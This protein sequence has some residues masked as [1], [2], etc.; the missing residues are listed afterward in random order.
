MKCNKSLYTVS[1][2]EKVTK[3]KIRK[4]RSSCFKQTKRWKKMFFEIGLT[5]PRWYIDPTPHCPFKI[6]PSHIP[7]EKEMGVLGS[8]LSRKDRYR[9]SLLR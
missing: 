7:P 9:G 5:L 6:S 2:T 1:K 8:L 4:T 3:N